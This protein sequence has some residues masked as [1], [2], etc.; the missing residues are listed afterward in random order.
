MDGFRDDH[1]G[2][3][4]LTHASGPDSGPWVGT[5]TVLAQNG[6]TQLYSVLQGIAVGTSVSMNFATAVSLEQAKQR[7]DDL[8]GLRDCNAAAVA[9]K[10]YERYMSEFRNA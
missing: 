10:P 8:L 4:I 7:I 6:R 5:Y 2:Y 9:L 1:K 3:M